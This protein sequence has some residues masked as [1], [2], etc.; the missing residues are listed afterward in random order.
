M[1]ENL[2]IVGVIIACV[3][4]ICCII[5]LLVRE[6]TI[7]KNCEVVDGHT[8]DR[9]NINGRSHV[10]HSLDCELCAEHNK[11][12]MIHI[13]DSVIKSNYRSNY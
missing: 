5:W 9:V 2:K 6:P 13:A 12:I 7:K 1:K 11:Q 10:V 4:A 3:L 8:Y